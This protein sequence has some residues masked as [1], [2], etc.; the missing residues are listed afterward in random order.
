MNW[1]LIR[2]EG[3]RNPMTVDELCSR[4]AEWLAAEYEALLI[5]M[6]QQVAGYALFRRDPEYIYLRQFYVRPELRRRGIGRAALALLHEQYWQSE[7]VRVEVLVGNTAGVAFWRALGFADYCLTLELER[8][9]SAVKS[10]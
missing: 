2:D 6:D 9:E 3:H 10:Q 5:E 4:M 8:C 1:R 7:R